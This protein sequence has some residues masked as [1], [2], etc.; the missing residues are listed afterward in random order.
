MNTSSAILLIFSVILIAATI[1]TIYGFI[2]GA[3]ILCS[4]KR[5]VQEALEYAAIKPGEKFYELGMGTGKVL[6]LAHKYFRVKP[7]GFE[8]SPFLFFIAKINLWI[9]GADNA[10]LFMK[11]FYKENLNGADIIFCF[12]TPHAMKKLRPKFEQELKKGARVISYAFSIKGW[13][14]EK[15]VTSY[16]RAKVFVYRFK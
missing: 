4:S 14:P 7:T 5:A 6:I 2:I 11:N 13:E 8:L 1:R 9:H 3:P 15:V 12:L 16:P 10:N